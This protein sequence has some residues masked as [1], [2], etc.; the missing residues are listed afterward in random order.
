MSTIFRQKVVINGVTFNDAL[1]QPGSAQRWGIDIMDGWKDTGDPDPGRVELGSYRDGSASASFFPVRTKFVTLGGYVLASDGATAEQLAD[2]L[3]RDAFP[4]NRTFQ[5]ARYE[6]VPKFITARRESAVS[7]EW[8]SMMEN[9]FRWSTTVS[10]DD[11]FKY[12]LTTIGGS[13]G[14][15]GTSL[16]GHSF[17]VTFPMSFTG[18]SSTE[19]SMAVVNAGTASSQNFTASISGP[20]NKG[21][22]QLVN[23]TTDE[24]IGFNVAI[25]TTDVL[26][27]DF[28]NQIA[29]I[30]GF[31]L[32]SDYTG[33][34]WRLAPGTNT[35]RL[36]A[37]YNADASVSLTGYSAWE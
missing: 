9:G 31:P 22:W 12:A 18:S 2:V 20:L 34:F 35:I 33:A 23:E 16:T 5:L 14:I 1:A 7:F 32:N 6:A 26:V 17:P 19:Q 30:N 27:I 25:G 24:T 13:T 36:Y 15:S 37:E 21:A 11:P 4:R 8:D 10:A 28:L 3:T 29:T